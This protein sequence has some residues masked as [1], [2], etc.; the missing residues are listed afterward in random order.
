MKEKY[1]LYVL[2]LIETIQVVIEIKRI[3][4]SLEVMNHAEGN[5]VSICLRQ[6]I[7]RIH[8]LLFA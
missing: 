6:H 4:N 2:S 3:Q 5:L 7:P 1:D 8:K